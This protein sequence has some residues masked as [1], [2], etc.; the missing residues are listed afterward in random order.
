M[1]QK[2]FTLVELLVVISVIA[3]LATI[4]YAIF[5]G[6]RKQ[7][8]MAKIVSDMQA[9]KTAASV[10]N[11]KYGNY[12]DD[13]WPGEN[14]GLDTLDQWPTSPCAPDTVY[15]WDK[16]QDWNNRPSFPIVRVSLRR[17][18]DDTTIFYMCIEE[19]KLG[20]C[21]CYEDNFNTPGFCKGY[22]S[23]ST[24]NLSDIDC[25]DILSTTKYSSYSP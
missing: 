21:T 16:W 18:N 5:S 3:I 2:G 14:P 24:D 15:D 22:N 1:H 12:P 6:T 11:Y 8:V 4:G 17:T 20:T 10:Y 19:N 7:A 13:V 25:E 23:V 9:I